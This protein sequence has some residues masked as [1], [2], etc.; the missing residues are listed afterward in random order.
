MKPIHYVF[1]L[2][3]LMLLTS[4]NEF[5]SLKSQD[6][7]STNFLSIESASKEISHVNLR[8]KPDNCLTFF[9]SIE[10]SKS[11]LN[12]KIL[13]INVHT[14]TKNACSI[15]IRFPGLNDGNFDIEFYYET[16]SKNMD[17]FNILAQ[18]QRG[19]LI[20]ETS[21]RDIENLGDMAFISTR[22]KLDQ[23]VLV[24][25]VDNVR[26]MISTKIKNNQNHCLFADKQ[27]EILAKAILE[28][29]K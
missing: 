26:I 6:N 20:P 2:I 11:C 14:E 23:K 28:K 10:L 7:N 8:V 9:E 25:T 22:P 13:D 12:S 15:D 27:L 18:G 29:I 21:S 3:A 5:K 19:S 16:E 1:H 4:C 17:R 24:T